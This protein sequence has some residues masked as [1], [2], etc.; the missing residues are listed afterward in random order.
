MNFL[1]DAQLPPA[2]AHLITSLGHRA[3]H[4]EEARLHLAEDAAIWSFA[5]TEQ[6]VIVTKDEDFKNR[7]LLSQ[8]L[9]TPVVWIRIGNCSNAA[10]AQWFQ[11]L[12][13]QV[14]DHLQRGEL[15]VELY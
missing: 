10:L 4:V 3:I 1:I 14:L 12:F 11:P 2:L 6:Y 8:G 13:P 7:L 5:V 15:L 9:K